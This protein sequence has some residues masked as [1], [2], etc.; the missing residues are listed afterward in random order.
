MQ[1]TY[2]CSTTSTKKVIVPPV[3]PD[4]DVESNG[5]SN[6]DET[7]GNEQDA[8]VNISHKNGVHVTSSVSTAPSFLCYK[9]GITSCKGHGEG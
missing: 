5:L 7:I 1:V 2:Q 4:N 8:A 3:L 6:H 9:H